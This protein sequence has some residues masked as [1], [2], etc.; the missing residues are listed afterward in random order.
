[1]GMRPGLTERLEVTEAEA[2]RRVDAVLAL[3][4]IHI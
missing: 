4:L 1:M 3:S 2:G